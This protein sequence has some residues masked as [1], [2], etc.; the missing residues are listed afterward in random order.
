LVDG[1]AEIERDPVPFLSLGL[2]SV[3]WLDRA[4]PVLRTAAESAPVE[5]DALIHLDVRSD[6]I[7][8]AARGAVLVD[9]NLVHRVNPDLDLAAWAPSLQM[10]G[11]PAPEQLVPGA[12]LLAAA[13][14]GFFA[15]RAGLLPPPTAPKV[16]VVQRAQ[17]EVALPWACRELGIKP[18]T[19]P[20][21]P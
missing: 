19:P 17:L 14:A 4:L 18:A 15:S 2:C 11:G 3:E 16:R 20:Q 7:C 6:N 9:W 8:L 1:W 5:G 13:L 21:A 10:E 12:G